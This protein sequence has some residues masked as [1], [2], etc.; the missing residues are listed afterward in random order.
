MRRAAKIDGNHA[1][2]VRVLLKAGATVLSLAHI[3]HGVPDILVGFRKR[4]ILMEIKD[5]SQSPSKR[6]LT[7]DQK[8]FHAIWGGQLAIVESAEEAL[9]LLA[10]N[11]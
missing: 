7:A 3:G 4:N 5:S 11:K 1:E 9:Q 8:L 10:G 6:R 2:I